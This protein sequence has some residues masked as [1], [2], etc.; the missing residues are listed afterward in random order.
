M[1]SQ[2]PMIT[3][4]TGCDGSVP[5]TITSAIVG[6]RLGAD[7]VEVDVR[8]TS[9]GHVVLS[10]DDSVS[11][12]DGRIVSIRETDLAT[13]AALRVPHTLPTID[14]LFDAVLGGAGL[15]NLDIKDEAALTGC[16]GLN[17]HYRF[18][19]PRPIHLAAQRRLNVSVWTVGP[20][21]GFER[22]IAMG[23]DSITTRNVADLASLR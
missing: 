10:H 21:D 5:N 6:L 9:D 17:I 16:R 3:A 1:I 23:A 22:Y 18:C 8:V 13:I 14:D 19:T 15:I 2:F 12:V 11:L 20:D 4:H 7:A